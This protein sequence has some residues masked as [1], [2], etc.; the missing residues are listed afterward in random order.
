MPQAPMKPRR[1][2]ADWVRDVEKIPAGIGPTWAVAVQAFLRDARARNCSPASIDNYRHY[3]LGQRLQQFL[4]DYSIVRPADVTVQH[5]REL[6]ADLLD[7]GLAPG[8]VGT[9]HR[10]LHNFLGFCK[11]EGWGIVPEILDAKPPR[12]PSVAPE[13][14]SDAEVAELMAAARYPRD[15]FLLEFMLRTGL[16]LKEVTAVTLDDIVDAPNG[17]YVRVRQGK[18]GKDRIVPLDTPGERFSKRVYTYIRKVR[19]QDSKDRHLFLGS[20]RD[21]DT[22]EYQGLTP[23]GVQMLV[24]RLA[25]QTGIHMHPHKFRHTFATNALRAGVD[26]IVLQRA[27]GHSTLAMVNRYV[28]F[29]ADDL[30]DAWSERR[31]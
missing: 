28:H 10:I 29:H 21:P 30:L 6:Q 22:D 25:N 18:G 23:R 8:T 13:A 17:S 4:T 7:A 11:R 19:P 26:S 20:R 27:L 3:L 9:F 5:F 31:D 2:P 15:R 16:R 24:K 14:F 1:K 12:Q